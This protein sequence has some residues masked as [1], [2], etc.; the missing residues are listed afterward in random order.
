METNIG[1]LV[2][3]VGAMGSGKT[4]KLI[5]LYDEMVSDGIRVAI[6]KPF[7]A[8]EGEDN[9]F[10]R[11]KD[12]RKAPAIAVDYLYEISSISNSERL[13]AIMVDEAQFFDEEEYGFQI[14]EGL[15]MGGLE[16]Y[17]FGLD[18][19]SENHTFG[20]MGDILAHA[21]EVNKLRA[22]C[23]KCG[24]EARISKY[25]G[26][27]KGEG[28]QV[29][30]VDDYTPQCRSCYHGWKERM[31]QARNKVEITIRRNDFFFVCSVEADRLLEMGYEVE[32]IKDRLQSM[33][34][35]I[36]FL[37]ELKKVG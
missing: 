33:D 7:L 18:V 9:E 19:D 15:A 17:V 21:D 24:E 34:E 20:H 10:V 6:F 16:V 27:S 2:V 13:Q 29:G 12:G 37:A 26:E 4:K 31:E 23:V 14:L 22:T 32:S 35:V 8:C 3:Y 28:V 11:T 5:D 1:R 25:V 30:G 36:T